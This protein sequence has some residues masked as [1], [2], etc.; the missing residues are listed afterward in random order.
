MRTLESERNRREG[1]LLRENK[2]KVRRCSVSGAL[3]LSLCVFIYMR[4]RWE[5]SAHGC[6]REKSSHLTNEPFA[7]WDG[8]ESGARKAWLAARMMSEKS[9]GIQSLCIGS[10]RGKE[11][12]CG[13]Q[14]NK[15]EGLTR[16]SRESVTQQKIVWT[17]I[18]SK[19][20]Y[21]TK[22]RGSHSDSLSF[23]KLVTILLWFLKLNTWVTLLLLKVKSR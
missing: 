11:R 10:Y 1:E 4:K 7:L 5:P 20:S 22:S 12:N 2:R 13:F 19:H 21:V 15:V 18:L 23:S 14:V 6:R 16:I 3:C 9:E 17:L 8:F